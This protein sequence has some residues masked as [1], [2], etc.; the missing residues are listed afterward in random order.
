MLYKRLTEPLTL[1]RNGARDL[2]ARQQTME[3]AIAWSY[4]LL[5]QTQQQRFRA[6]GAFVGGWTLEAEEAVCRAEQE[7]PLEESILTI[8]ALVTAC[9]VQA[10][11]PSYGP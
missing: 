9:M 3:E 2:P 8:D 7:K 1:L 5:T 4:D 10:D 6:L 11:I